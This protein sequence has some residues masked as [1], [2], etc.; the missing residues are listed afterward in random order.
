[1][2]KFL[3]AALLAVSPFFAFGQTAQIKANEKPLIGISCQ[4]PGNNSQS[5]LTYTQSVIKAGGIPVLIP[6]TEDSLIL[7]NIINRI[8]GIIMIG[9]EDIHPSYYGEEAIPELGKV[10]PVR[11]VYDIALIKMA[12]DHN[13]PMLGICR[14]EQ[15]INVAFGGTLYQDIP[16]QCQDT[17]V[18][19]SQNEPSSTPTHKINILP[20]SQIAN[21]FGETE[22]MTNTHHHQAVKKVAPGFKATAWATDSIVEAIENIEGYPIWGTQFHPETRTVAGDETS[23]RIFKFIVEKADIFR[24][25]KNIHKKY[26]TIDTHTDTPLDFHG[27]YNLGRR[28]WTQVSVPAMEEGYLDAQY[29]ACWIAQGPCDE[30]HSAEAVQLIDSLIGCI[31]KQVEMNKDV[32]GIA[33]TAD[34]LVRLKAEGKKAF[35]IGIEN[36]YGIG[37]DLNN[38]KRFYDRGVSYITLCHTKHNDLCDSSSDF[39]K[40]V[41]GLTKMGKK[42]VKIMDKLGILIDLS[43]AHDDTFWDVA[44]VSKKPLF[45]SHSASRALLNHDRNL[46]D[47]QLRAVAKSNGVVQ[48]CI[49]DLFLNKNP[50][51]ATLDDFMTHLY[52]MIEVAGID[53]IGIGSDFDGGGGVKGCQGD[54]DFINI[55]TRLIEKGYS[56]EDI[57]KI[58][59]GNFLRVMREVQGK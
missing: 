36:G 17:T 52:H 30:K 40:G 29:L 56:D 57:A 19:H 24:R 35:Y 44:K 8:D 47:E 26:Y 1:M 42:A 37:K 16:A 11:D 59:G 31:E 33:R 18:N 20:G 10:D 39:T 54:N 58:W 51:A 38:I 7:R 49:V 53:H 21:I 41:G 2:I 4:R 15:L 9:G 6:I 50:K 25:A 12:H 5:R 13:I 55:T 28:E 48:V 22:M 3:L 45:A 34:D 43:H 14:G 23:L 46:T 27:D 32:C